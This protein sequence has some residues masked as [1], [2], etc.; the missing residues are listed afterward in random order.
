MR[1]K[2]TT[3]ETRL[4]AKDSELIVVESLNKQIKHLL[5]KHISREQELNAQLINLEKKVTKFQ[6]QI[7]ELEEGTYFFWELVVVRRC[8]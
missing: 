6:N 1:F 3:A 4:K 8:F 5:D 2:L 7:S